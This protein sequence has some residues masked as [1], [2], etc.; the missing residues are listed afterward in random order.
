[1]FRQFTT[2]KPG[3]DN[4]PYNSGPTVD[5]LDR[6]YP[7]D[8]EKFRLTRQWSGQLKS[9]GERISSYYEFTFWTSLFACVVLLIKRYSQLWQANRLF[10]LTLLFLLAN[11]LVT[12]SV[13]LV[14]DRYQ[15]RVCWL[16]GLCCGAY[17]L[18]FAVNRLDEGPQ[19]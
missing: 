4:Y 11:A 19:N 16:V 10:F 15:S 8:I 3:V 9:I 6:L 7:G 5:A 13:S 18:S 14:S 1:M 2:F 12:A 17:V